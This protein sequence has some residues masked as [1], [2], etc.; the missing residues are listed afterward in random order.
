MSNS[1]NEKM[2]SFKELEKKIF[3]YVCELGCEITRSLL[4]SYDN[5]IA[6]RRDKKKYRIRERDRHVLKRF[7]DQWS[8]SAEYMERLL[9]VERR[10]MYIFWMKKCICISASGVWNMMQ[11]LG[12]KINKEEEHAVKQMNADQTEGK[13]LVYCLKKWMVCG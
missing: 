4:E 3:Q 13:R 12:E 10:H 9:K 8:I 2:I 6:S 1:V 11:L 7:M 5:D